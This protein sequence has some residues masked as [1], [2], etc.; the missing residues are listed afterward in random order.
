V[1][2]KQIVGCPFSHHPSALSVLFICVKVLFKRRLNCRRFE[3]CLPPSLHLSFRNQPTKCRLLSPKSHRT[4]ANPTPV[5][6]ANLHLLLLLLFNNLAIPILP[7]PFTTLTTQQQQPFWS[8]P[9]TLFIATRTWILP[10][11]K[12]N[13]KIHLQIIPTGHPLN[14]NSR[15]LSRQTV[16][17]PICLRIFPIPNSTTSNPTMLRVQKA[18]KP[19]QVKNRCN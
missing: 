5:L 6:S 9:S 12:P 1:K 11:T 3:K 14:M 4:N 15:L 7:S 8:T 2:P 19:D 10:I 17:L 13:E 16:A 18:F